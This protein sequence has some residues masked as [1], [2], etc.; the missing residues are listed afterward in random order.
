MESVSR[1][2]SPLIRLVIVIIILVTTALLSIF[3]NVEAGR[4]HQAVSG[5][6][7]AYNV[8]NYI[9]TTQ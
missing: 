5:V 8:S 9:D 3:F 1:K 4:V 2:G 7:E 6:L